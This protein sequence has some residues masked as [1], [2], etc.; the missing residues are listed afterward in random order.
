MTYEIDRNSLDHLVYGVM[1]LGTGGGGDPYYTS[2][3]LNRLLETGASVRV[4]APS[5]LNDDDLVVP[6]AM[7][8]AHSVGNICVLW[9]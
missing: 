1:F 3:M 4:V 5:Q 9:S 6:L 2:V 7:V 8:G